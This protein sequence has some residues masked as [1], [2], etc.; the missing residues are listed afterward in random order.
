MNNIT[1][2]ERTC[3]EAGWVSAADLMEEFYEKTSASMSLIRAFRPDAFND[4]AGEWEGPDGLRFYNSEHGGVSYSSHTW[5]QLAEEQEGTIRKKSEG[6][7]PD[8]N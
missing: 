1:D 3:R 4:V 2:C 6:K 5:Q 7:E 8:G